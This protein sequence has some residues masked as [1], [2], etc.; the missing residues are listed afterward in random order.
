VLLPDKHIRLSESILGF[1]GLVLSALRRPTTFDNLWKRL[2][3]SVDTPDWPAAHGVENF[4]LALC[5]LYS[6]GAV[7][8]SSDGELF[9]CG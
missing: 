9:R 2:Q 5:F 7:D 1:G 8:V 6:I 4:V 3:E